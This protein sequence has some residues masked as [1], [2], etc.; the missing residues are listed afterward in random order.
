[1]DQHRPWPTRW[2][3]KSLPKTSRH[4]GVARRWSWSCSLNQRGRLIINFVVF[5][6]VGRKQGRNRVAWA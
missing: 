5:F 4:H 6:F 1:M 2:C 3:R